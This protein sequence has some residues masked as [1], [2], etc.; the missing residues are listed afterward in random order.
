M[1]PP[2]SIGDTA[3]RV[4]LAVLTQDRPTVRAVGRAIGLSPMA[5]LH[6]LRKLRDAGLVDWDAGK[7][8]T[9]RASVAI[10]AMGGPR[11]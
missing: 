4:L 3:T 7:T 8:G 5:T 11:G 1:R 10:V 2:A 6:H 9:L